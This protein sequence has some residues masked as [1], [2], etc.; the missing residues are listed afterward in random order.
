MCLDIGPGL[1]FYHEKECKTKTFFSGHDGKIKRKRKQ[2]IDGKQNHQLRSSRIPMYK[3]VKVDFL[4]S[5]KQL[6]TIPPRKLPHENILTTI[7]P[8]LAEHAASA[9]HMVDKNNI[10]VPVSVAWSSKWVNVKQPI[11]VPKLSLS[12]QWKRGDCLVIENEFIHGFKLNNVL[13]F[14][15]KQKRKD[16]MLVHALHKQILKNYKKLRYVICYVYMFQHFSKALNTL[17]H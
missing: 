17:A 9:L 5:L 1:T 12:T 2:W 6:Y 16:S 8:S 7:S 14:F 3:K 13:D 15:M 10:P 4:T 11:N